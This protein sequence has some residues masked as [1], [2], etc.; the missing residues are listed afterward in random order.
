VRQKIHLA[1]PPVIGTLLVTSGVVYLLHANLM[2]LGAESG[3]WIIEML[4]LHSFGI[5]QEVEGIRNG[6]GFAIWQVWTYALLHDPDNIGHLVYNGIFLW[7]FG[8][9]VENTWGPRVLGGFVLWVVATAG[10][11]EL[12]AAE[13]NIRI[14]GISGL[15]YGMMGAYLLL[16]GRQIVSLLFVYRVPGWSVVAAFIVL[17]VTM[18]IGG[19]ALVGDRSVGHIT[20]LTGFGMGVVGAAVI[21]GPTALAEQWRRQGRI[22]RFLYK[23]RTEEKEYQ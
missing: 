7:F 9:N 17:E 1:V 6:Q 5:G 21:H 12:I 4:A 13:G 11:M 2:M 19:G 16:Y 20:H 3:L 23:R 22:N 18:L 10:L 8:Q 15:V 14:F